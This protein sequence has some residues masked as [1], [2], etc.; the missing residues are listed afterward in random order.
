M[1]DTLHAGSIAFTGF[2]ADGNDNLAFVALQDLAAGTV[3]FFNENEWLGSAFNSGEGVWSWTASQNVSAGSIVS[4]DNLHTTGSSNLG[5]INVLGGAIDLNVSSEIV[6]AYVGSSDVPATFLSAI[7]NNL[8][9]VTGGTLNG[10]GLTQ[11]VNAISLNGVT[12]SADTATYVGDRAGQTSFSDYLSNINN[13]THWIGEDTSFDDSADGVAPDVPFSVAGFSASPDTQ[14][15]N[16][17]AGSLTVAQAEGDSGDTV[18][19]FTVERTGSSGELHFAGNLVASGV[20]NAADFGGTLPTSFSGSI[21][22]GATS[23]TVSIHVSG[24][25][26]FEGDERFSLQLQSVSNDAAP[27]VLGNSTTATGVIANDDPVAAKIAFVGYADQ[28]DSALAFAALSDIAAGTEIHFAANESSVISGFAIGSG[29]FTWTASENIKAGTIVTLDHLATGAATSNHGAIEFTTG[30]HLSLPTSREVIYAYLG[31]ETQP[32]TFLTAFANFSFVHTLDGT[33]LTDGVDAVTIKNGGSAPDIA[34]YNGP[35]FGSISFDDYLHAINNPANWISERSSFGGTA[36]DGVT[37][38]LPFPTYGFSIDPTAQVVDF[39]TGSLSV[40]HAEGASGATT[41]FTF[42]VERA[43]GAAGD[44]AF[45]AAVKAENFVGAA[46][47]ADFGGVLP[48]VSGVIAAGQTSATVTVT[49]AGDAVY[50]NDETFHLVLQ[51]ASN[52]DASSVVVGT[53]TT[54]TGTITN[55]EAEPGEIFAG[56][57]VTRGIGLSGTDFVTIDAGGKLDLTGGG[58]TPIDWQ[59]GNATIDNSGD[60]LTSNQSTSAAILGDKNVTGTLAITN[61]EGATVFGEIDTHKVAPARWSPSPMP[62]PSPR[63]PKRSRRR[64]RRPPAKIGSATSRPAS[65]PPTPRQPTSSV[66]AKTT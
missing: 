35:R 58:S 65:S 47:A 62:A 38:D 52:P 56:Q 31:S 19:T 60:I 14:V 20:V 16:F 53:N 22:D 36:S 48:V 18:L 40:T 9:T 64:M 23:G 32:T 61:H 3:I 17:A 49:V 15:L 44:L 63:T 11:G 24:D 10:T 7:A 8:F 4:M 5:T 27:V 43:N 66:P 28:A 26:Q 50:E 37:P 30:D 57:T 41:T 33:G 12:G 21:V 6:Y 59:G 25:T 46:N 13:P 39:A 1:T 51:S 45:T 2:N 34:I 54:V 42:T 55:D 29:A